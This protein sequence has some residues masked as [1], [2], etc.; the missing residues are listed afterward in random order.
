MLEA[1]SLSSSSPI[2]SFPLHTHMTFY[3][4]PLPSFINVSSLICLCGHLFKI[5]SLP[6]IQSL[7]IFSEKWHQYIPYLCQQNYVLCHLHHFVHSRAQIVSTRKFEYFLTSFAKSSREIY[8]SGIWINKYGNIS[9]I[10]KLLLNVLYF[11]IWPPADVS[12]INTNKMFYPLSVKGEQWTYII[13][14]SY[15]IV[16]KI[17]CRFASSL[18]S[19]SPFSSYSSVKGKLRPFQGHDI[20]RILGVLCTLSLA[21]LTTTAYRWKSDVHNCLHLGLNIYTT[22]KGNELSWLEYPAKLLNLLLNYLGETICMM[23]MEIDDECENIM[24][25]KSVCC[26]SVLERIKVLKLSNAIAMLSLRNK[27]T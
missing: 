13:I 1:I 3:M 7:A 4:T 8:M 11:N 17:H 9:Q 26:V 10:Q 15:S 21:P 25:E 14:F 12:Y 20:F 22:E 6:S 27:Y 23:L 5:A 19:L 16:T 2:R 18:P 24:Q